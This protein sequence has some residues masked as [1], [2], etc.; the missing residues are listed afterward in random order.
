MKTVQFKM[1]STEKLI[2]FSTVCAFSL[3]INVATYAQVGI[4]TTNPNATLDITSSNQATPSASDGLL[5]P[6]V[7]NF[8]AINPSLDQNGML[9]FRTSDNIFYYWDHSTTSWIPLDSGGNV[10][11][12]DDLF[13]GKSDLDGT[14]NGSSIF[15]GINAGANDDL[16]DNKN[17][18]LGFE[19]LFSNTTGNNNIA[20]GFQA[21]HTNTIGYNNIATGYLS[22]YANTY[23]INNVAIGSSALTDNTT[24]NFNT[25]LNTFSLFSNTTGDSNVALGYASLLSN[26]TGDGNLAIGFE[27]LYANTA[28]YANV[29]NGT[30]SLFANTTGHHNL[31]MGHRSLW[32]NTTGQSNIAIGVNAMRDNT[33]GNYNIAT[34][35]EALHSN[36]TGSHN[37]ASGYQ[38]LYTNTTGEYN[39]AIGFQSLRNNTTGSNN[40]ARGN[41]AL[42][43]NTTGGNNIAAGFQSLRSNTTGANNIANGFFSLYSNSTGANNIANGF[44]S[45]FANTTGSNN[46]SN[47]N[48]SLRVN[49]TGVNNI[50]NGEN[51][52]RNNT[53]GSNNIANGNRSLY[54]NITGHNNIAFGYQSLYLN[55]AGNSNI[56]IGYQAGYNETGS[57]KLYIENSFNNADNALVYGEF[58]TN[59]IRFNGEIEVG[60]P[61]SSSYLEIANL[62][63]DNLG[64]DGNIIPFAGS[65][66]GYDLGNNT[67][68]E[69]W[70]DVVA[71]SFV[72]FSDRNTKYNIRSLAYGLSEIM[73][74]EPVT[75]QYKKTISP[76]DRTRIG[77]IAQDVEKVVPEVVI[78]EDVDYNSNT[79]EIIRVTANLKAL[80]YVELLPVL[81]KAI[82]EQQRLI[83][84]Q[85]DQILIQKLMIETQ[86]RKMNQLET[87]LKSQQNEI[88]AIKELLK[89][90]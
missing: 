15:L 76:N 22:L 29:A 70:D 58:D 24:G 59:V 78:T 81:I 73:Q 37:I 72:T 43:S 66:S 60:V 61:G 25:A 40:V 71:N 88:N 51:T 55:S 83:T 10:D 49:T 68:N 4:N 2:C 6:K 63:S 11:R 35:S 69:H 48:Q 56:A 28:G 65:A 47:G 34:G 32:S 21:L 44:F 19:A 20:N 23:G 82:Q 27:A 33:T 13:D 36:T 77:L 80:T 12:I 79:G 87:A 89:I 46:I 86:K 85:D 53:T 26:T 1:L 18:G 38:S 64:L 17:I 52:L 57:N 8:S 50:A 90:Q 31:A 54:T 14:N 45:L 7:D 30:Q 5:I 67:A 16:S 9:V 39:T 62:G 74:L 75:Y 42:Y 3:F 84:A 41:Q